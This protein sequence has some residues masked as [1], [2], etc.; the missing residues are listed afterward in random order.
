M[1]R[2]P[3]YILDNIGIGVLRS[4]QDEFGAHQSYRMGTAG[5][6]PQRKVAEA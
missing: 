6:Y 2:P 4:A 5:L 3:P 1:D